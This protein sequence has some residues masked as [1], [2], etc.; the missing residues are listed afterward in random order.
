MALVNQ[1]KL[2]YR[3]ELWDIVRFQIAFYCH[4]N[5]ISITEQNLDCL[6]LLGISGETEIG[7]FCDNSSKNGIFKNHQSARTALQLLEKKE[8]ITTFKIGKTKKQMKL[9]NKLVVQTK[10]NIFVNLK[11]LRIE[12]N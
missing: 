5:K 1:I 11:I 3:M 8:L 7:D 10:G 4:L 2:E 6:T 9:H 12:T